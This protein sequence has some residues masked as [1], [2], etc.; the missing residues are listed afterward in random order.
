[1]AKVVKSNSI[2][3]LGFS[4]DV[5]EKLK[6][7]G[8]DSVGKLSQDYKNLITLLPNFFSEEEQ[9][10]IK[11]ILIKEMIPT[12]FD[13][14]DL[15]SDL[16][17][18]LKNK[19]IFT[20]PNLLEAK[21]E[22]RTALYESLKDNEDLLNEVNDLFAR[23]NKPV[24]SKETDGYVAPKT[25]K[26][27]KET[28]SEQNKKIDVEE[29]T[30]KDPYD[31]ID[32]SER[33]T[34]P[35]DENQLFK[36]NKKYSHMR[37]RLA[38]PAEIRKWS[39]G[40]ILSHET[41][42]YKNG[43][44]IR[45]GLFAEEIFGPVKD[46]T[47]ACGNKNLAKGSTCPTCG[48]EITSSRVRRERMGHIELGT[49][50]INPLFI[51]DHVN[52]TLKLL[53]QVFNTKNRDF[54]R[55]T[56][57]Q[58]INLNRF[59]ITDNGGIEQVRVNDIVGEEGIRFLRDNYGNK[60]KFQ[61]GG[62]AIKYLLSK[63]DI[64]K[65]INHQK[66]ILKNI[67][68]KSKQAEIYK[69]L[70][71]L[72]DFYNADIK[73][74]WIVTDVIPVMPPDLRPIVILDGGQ[75]AT[76]GTNDLYRDIINRSN[77]FKELKKIGA[78]IS[79][80]NNE[81]RL[82]QKGVND[83]FLIFDTPANKATSTKVNK[84]S[85]KK[86]LT[87]KTGIF[88]SNLLGKRVD[89]SARSVII[90]GPDLKMYQCGVPREM[91]LILFKPFILKRLR[92]IE[93]EENKNN[94]KIYSSTNKKFEAKERIVYEIL[95]EVV[96]EHPVLLNRAPTLHRLGIQAFEP[97]LIDG[98]AIRL[99]PL[100][101]TAFN[102]D[103]DGDQM[104]IHL[105]LSDEAIAEARIL[106]L[107]SNNILKPSDGK[108][109]VTPSQDMV[110]GNYY[111]TMELPKNEDELNK[112]LNRGVINDNVSKYVYENRNEGKIFSS[113]DELEAAFNNNE[114]SL[115]TRILVDASTIDSYFEEEDRSA[116]LITTYGKILFNHI[117][118]QSFPYLQEPK[119][120]NLLNYI[121]RDF[122]Y[123]KEDIKNNISVSDKLTSLPCPAPFNKA[124]LSKIIAQI[125][126]K[127]GNYETSKMLDRMKDLGF[128]YS[129]YSGLSISA[130]DVNVYSKKQEELV[131]A[132]SIVD[133]TEALYDL[134]LLSY[135]EKKER[136]TKIWKELTE[137]IK[138]GLMKE[139]KFDNPVFMMSN[140]GAR[141]SASNF[142]QLIG[143]RGLMSNPKGEVIEVPVKSS[144]REGL[145]V[146]EF[147]ISTH[148][149]RKGSIDTALMTSNS[150]Y[151]TRRLVDVSQDVIVVEEDCGSD[152]G[153]VM[154]EI[155]YDKDGKSK[156]NL[157]DRIVGR[158]AARD[159]YADSTLLVSRNE[160]IDEDIARAIIAAGIKEVE[161]RSILTCNSKNGVCVKC[162]G[163]NLS[164]SK[165]IEV[166]EAVGVI[167]AQSIGEPGTQ[168]TMRTFHTGGVAA[169]G[170]ITQ[171]LPGVLLLLDTPIKPTG[172]NIATISEF[173]GKVVKVTTTD[174]KTDVILRNAETGDDITIR[175]DNRNRI[176]VKENEV[177]EA[178]QELTE[179]YVPLKDILKYKNLI[180]TQTY[181]L[182]KVKKVYKIQDVDVS[183][184]HIE[185]MIRQMSK[186]VRITS[187]G[188][189]SLLPGSILS[190]YEYHQYI[191]NCLKEG[192]NP[193]IARQM[194]KGIK[195]VANHSTSFI[196]SIS[197]EQTTKNLINEV[198]SGKKDLLYGLKEN[199]IIGGL[200]PNGTGMLQNEKIIF[201]NEELK[202]D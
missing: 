17:T 162:Y 166:G 72:L 78:P 169:G 51:S 13:Q 202:N 170:D 95:E 97:K 126:D 82:I 180:N 100:V 21:A 127:Y 33:L 177:F 158:Y 107:A 160:M 146:S 144:F 105:P 37:I 153:Y 87:G 173:E 109:I 14:L 179:G 197:F 186:F 41:I 130:F 110:I 163:R 149:A 98:K 120:E 68:S 155:L 101:C 30:P 62:E 167:A 164:T 40:E 103:F 43:K 115:H 55:E 128:K 134:G 89:Y 176:L 7:Y 47:C 156:T 23:Y 24:L 195:Y 88:R 44:P 56:I 159:V 60:I 64:E 77:R 150:G 147:F 172:K 4:S 123:T 102:A 53:L 5:L 45:G 131:K 58:I 178:G 81:R 67:K 165:P 86:A 32:L 143:M 137:K 16:E 129:T 119:V 190:I 22:N 152:K 39:F 200:I 182:E 10:E 34:I 154:K 66:H 48:V 92:D 96:R 12:S 93:K 73:P 106:M 71:L 84:K 145:T 142:S 63:I 125:F 198:I 161:V 175:V 2:D 70:K 148:G 189:S 111:L 168:L 133:E 184:K 117:L 74:E 91:A 194:I 122:L 26:S 118:P 80:L 114:I 104:A 52:Q 54:S 9:N 38:S 49:N 196:S 42:S 36:L 174:K 75:F 29:E 139:F 183:D 15:S 76:N 138:D 65:E 199:T 8:Y 99:H 192:K 191:E 193:P 57:G 3:K 94:K 90:V 59:I 11:A 46:Y 124:F 69:V 157:F 31:E 85:I 19:S 61:T 121:S 185:I 20:L 116:Y 187:A 25:T 132:Q 79:I 35:D 83:L 188:D 28:A 18:I 6:V 140:S 113:F 181:V 171:G 1:M 141:G 108:P 135:E 201:N 112:Y 136:T 151:F 50:I 27:D